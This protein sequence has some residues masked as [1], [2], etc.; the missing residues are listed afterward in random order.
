VGRNFRLVEDVNKR[1]VCEDGSCKLLTQSSSSPWQRET[2][3]L[4]I[5]TG[6]VF[7]KCK[8]G[9]VLSPE[10]VCFFKAGWEYLKFD[11]GTN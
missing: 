9:S 2:F 11:A 6:S 10:M 1:G 3:Q 8:T 5:A 4:A 7:V